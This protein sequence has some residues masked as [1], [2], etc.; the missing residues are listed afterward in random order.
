[1][2]TACANFTAF[3]ILAL[4]PPGTPGSPPLQLRLST[5]NT[6]IAVFTEGAVD[7]DGY[8][9]PSMTAPGFFLL[10]ERG[11]MGELRTLRAVSRMD[12]YTERI[13]FEQGRAVPVTEE[14]AWMTSALQL[15]G[16][17]LA[18]RAR[19]VRWHGAPLGIRGVYPL[20]RASGSLMRGLPATTEDT[21]KGVLVGSW[22]WGG[23][24]AGVFIAAAPGRD[25]SGARRL[26]RELAEN[27][28]DWSRL[29][30]GECLVAYTWDPGTAV[31]SV[32]EVERP[33]AGHVRVRVT[34]GARPGLAAAWL[35][36]LL[37]SSPWLVSL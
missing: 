17:K 23:L 16:A 1:M 33:G 2:R 12:G 34:D 6:T 36:A 25:P 4:G 13:A 11:A 10:A 29:Q 26:L 7:L 27:P 8:A 18:G 32:L 14:P 20:V 15:T 24:R 22:R 19:A 5:S 21:E 3:A 9:A 35:G 30:V 28:G 37:G 31:L